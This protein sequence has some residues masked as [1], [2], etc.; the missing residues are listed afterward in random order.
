MNANNIK[1]VPL[2]YDKNIVESF[3]RATTCCDIL[4]WE[5][6]NYYKQYVKKHLL[7]PNLSRCDRALLMRYK[8]LIDERLEEIGDRFMK[9]KNHE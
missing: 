9:K 1:L 5:K 4:F 8:T 2:K 3:N 7:K 6:R